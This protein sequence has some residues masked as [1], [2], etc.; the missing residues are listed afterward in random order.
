MRDLVIG[1]RKRARVL[2][3]EDLAPVLHADGQVARVA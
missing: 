3:V 2:E 1:D